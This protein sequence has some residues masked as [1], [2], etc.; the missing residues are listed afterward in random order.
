MK[1]WRRFFVFALL[2]MT[3]VLWVSTPVQAHSLCQRVTARGVGQDNFDGTT[4]ARIYDFGL[5]VGTTTASFV[6]TGQTGSVL[7]ISGTVVFHTYR[8][9]LTL[10]V[11]GT[12]DLSTGVFTTTGPVTGATGYLRGVTGNLTLAGVEDLTTGS[13]TERITGRLCL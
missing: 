12:V 5:L 8:S 1:G 13:F 11:T 10:T 7:G 4:Q 9:T 6:P 2:V 3:T